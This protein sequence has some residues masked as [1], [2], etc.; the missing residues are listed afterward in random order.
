MK[1]IVTGAAGFVGANLTRHLLASGHEPVA[2]VRRSGPWRLHDVADALDVRPVDL[3]DLDATRACVRDVNPDVIFHL[4][5]YGAY[6]WQR[7]FDTMLAVNVRATE[8]LLESA[9]ASDARLVAT[10][11]SSE[12]GL[13]D[14]APSEVELLEP[15][16]QY[17]VTKACATH[18][19]RLAARD[20]DQH[21][22]TLR[23]YS[24]YGPWEEPGRLMPALVERALAG[25]LPPLV[26]P[27]TARDFVWIDDACDALVRAASPE[28]PGCGPVFNIASGIQSTLRGL[29]EVIRELFGVEREPVWGTMEQRNWDTSCWVGEPAAARDGLGWTVRTP[30]RDGLVRFADW[31]RANPAVADRYVAP[32]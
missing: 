32:R 4:A 9:R 12:Y 27:D 5:A 2:L 22:V 7:D 20:H 30:I 13:K 17:A 29:V 6:G 21:A 11:S 19:C 10:G 25:E 18:L 3:R 8:V 28:V 1:A 24:I 16:S 23:L 31:M 15:N 26:G 14:H